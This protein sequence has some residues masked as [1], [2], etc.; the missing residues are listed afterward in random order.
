MTHY[1]NHDSYHHTYH[2][3]S[4]HLPHSIASYLPVISIPA[5]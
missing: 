5:G 1:S 3:S 2:L 4:Y